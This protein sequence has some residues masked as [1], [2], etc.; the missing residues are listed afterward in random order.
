MYRA[1]KMYEAGEV[2]VL[3]SILMSEESVSYTSSLSMGKKQPMP[4]A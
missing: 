4:I 3:T 2:W 1:M